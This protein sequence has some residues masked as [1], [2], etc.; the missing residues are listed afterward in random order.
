MF[1]LNVKHVCFQGQQFWHE[2]IAWFA[3]VS[4]VVLD[5]KNVTIVIKYQLPIWSLDRHIYIL[6][7]SLLVKVLHIATVDILQV[8][9]NMENVTNAIK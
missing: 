3:N 5:R 6:Q 7:R 4:L 2:N 9:T 8:V 1:F